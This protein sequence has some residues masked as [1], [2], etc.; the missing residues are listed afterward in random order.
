MK[1]FEIRAATQVDVFPCAQIEAENFSEP[2]SANAL[3][4]ALTDTNSLFYVI[5]VQNNAVGYYIAGNICDEIN[6]YTIAVADE[7]KGKGCGKALL[8]HLIAL[9]K[10]M[11]ALFI[12]LEVRVSNE[13]AIAL[14]EQNGFIRNGK[15][16]DFYKK[17]TEDAYLYTLYLNEEMT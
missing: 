17:P 5:C 11:S 16:P 6:L 1:D 15:R 14:Y 3:T 2:W 7:Y 9:S 13:R 4:D 10:L 12:G 8:Q